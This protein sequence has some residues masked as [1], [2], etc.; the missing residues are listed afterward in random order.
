V[1]LGQYLWLPLDVCVVWYE[2]KPF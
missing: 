1:Q 2:R